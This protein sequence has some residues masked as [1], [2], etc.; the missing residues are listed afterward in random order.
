LVKILYLGDIV[1]NLGIE[2]VEMCLPEVISTNHIDFCIANCENISRGLGVSRGGLEKLREAGIDFFSSG[3]HVW[4]NPEIYRIFQEHEDIIRPANYPGNPVGSG[5]S[6]VELNFKNKKKVR[7][8]IMN[9]LGRLFLSKVNCPFLTAE[10]ILESEKGNFDIAL[11]DFHAE[12]TA[13][14]QALGYYLDGKV[15]L[16]VGTHTHV[17]TNDD[18]ILPEGTG[19]ITD[20]GMAG[21]LNSILGVAIEPVLSHFKNREFV[22]WKPED[23]FPAIMC[24]VIATINEENGKTLSI[25]KLRIEKDGRMV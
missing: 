12:T 2:M 3:N 8:I 18:R 6:I 23:R 4:D 11:V 25:E 7:V 17:M 21:A 5:Y 24:G 13:E 10:K 20:L 15:S 16:V 9:L 14:K 22:Q 19:Y 1:G